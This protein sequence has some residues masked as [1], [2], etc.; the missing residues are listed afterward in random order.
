MDQ[1][2]SRCK[3]VA[4]AV[5][6]RPDDFLRDKSAIRPFFGVRVRLAATPS[7]VT[8]NAVW[9]LYKNPV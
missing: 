3:P 9:L 7:V 6:R 8:I 5:D 4:H 1:Y 2:R